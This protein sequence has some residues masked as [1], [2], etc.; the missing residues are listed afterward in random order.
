MAAKGDE[1]AA[2]TPDTHA[3]HPPGTR[4]VPRLRPG[5]VQLLAPLAADLAEWRLAKWATV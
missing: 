2:D 4:I 5:V 3:R 1:G